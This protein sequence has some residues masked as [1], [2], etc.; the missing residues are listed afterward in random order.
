MKQNKRILFAL[1]AILTLTLVLSGCTQ[2]KD[3]TYVAVITKSTESTFWKY[4]YSGVNTA[5]NEYNVD[6]TFEGPEN[7]EDYNTQ[8][9]MIETA[10][11]NGA[12]AIVFSAI[13]Y[14][15]S[16]DEI[17]KA[18]NAGIPVVIIDSGIDSDKPAVT[19]ETDNYSAGQ[20]AASQILTQDGQLNVGIVN[21]DASSANGQEREQGFTDAVANE[22][23]VNIEAVIN[24]N[25]SIEDASEGTQQMLEEYPDIN[26]IVTFNEW[27]TLGVGYAIQNLGCQAGTYVV[28][29]DSNLIS[30]GMLET[31]EMDALI[32]QRPFVMGYLGIENAYKLVNKHEKV[33]SSIFTETTTIT[34]D[35]MFDEE[36]QK[37]LFPIE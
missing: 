31:G 6:F 22:Q 11:K 33:D 25:S 28:G 30:V 4:V 9:E 21:F 20:Q 16:V 7:E 3:K 19:I 32:V 5:S 37:I 17:E 29:F 27:T 14:T 34:Y 12:D 24:V 23:R 26:V 15:E 8:N 10:I 36:S 35:N 13:S 18:V 1:C 2:V